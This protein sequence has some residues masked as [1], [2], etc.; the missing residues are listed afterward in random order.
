MNIKSFDLNLL[1]AFESL[2]IERNVTRAAARSG[3]SQPAMSH[4]LSRLR[5]VFEDPLLMRT[6]DG[7]KPTPVAHSLMPAVRAI[8]REGARNNHRV[9]S[10]ILG[11]VK[12]TPFQ[13]SRAES[14]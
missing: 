9:T 11:I 1:L 12:S 8:T 14:N 6:T 7:M 5:R 3:L 10:L 4:A 2:M 13:M